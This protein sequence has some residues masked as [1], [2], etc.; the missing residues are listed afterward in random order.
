MVDIE[1]MSNEEI[2]KLFLDLLNE[3]VKEFKEKITSKCKI[4]GKGI[5]GRYSIQK[6]KTTS[7][8]I[9]YSCIYPTYTKETAKEALE[10]FKKY[11]N[12]ITLYL[13]VL[14]F[15]YKD[16]T[17]D[18]DKTIVSSARIGKCLN[19]ENFPFDLPEIYVD[20]DD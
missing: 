8:Y 13:D 15:K 7:F 18:I 20:S 14:K 19:V 1:K 4:K 2:T 10:L 6:Y 3:Y 9:D 17:Y 12:I 5:S 11:A 16:I